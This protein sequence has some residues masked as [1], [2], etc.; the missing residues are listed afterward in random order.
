M[1]YKKVLLAS[2]L[3]LLLTVFGLQVV[4]EAKAAPTTNEVEFFKSEGYQGSSYTY[5]NGSDVDLYND[6]SG[7]NDQLHSVKVGNDVKVIGFRDDHFHGYTKEYTADTP[8]LEMG[9][10]SSFLVRDKYDFTIKFTFDDNTNDGVSSRCLTLEEYLFDKVT[11]C[12]NDAIDY[13][14]VIGV[15]EPDQVEETLA[16]VYLQNMDTGGYEGNGSIFFYWDKTEGVVKIDESTSQIPPQVTYTR[17]DSSTF[18][19]IAS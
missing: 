9:G 18:H 4:P 3:G 12:S 16:A 1:N 7:L 6:G 10:L 15:I 8:D 14:L 17:E 2:M 11:D 19:F 13:P 5:A